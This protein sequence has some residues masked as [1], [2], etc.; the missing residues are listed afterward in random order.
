MTFPKKLSYLVHNVSDN[1]CSVGLDLSANHCGVCVAVVI[2][3]HIWI[4]NLQCINRTKED[5]D[6]SYANKIVDIVNSLH[7]PKIDHITCE[8]VYLKKWG[9]KF[10]VYEFERVLRLQGMIEYGLRLPWTYTQASHA[11]KVLS[12]NPQAHKAEVQLFVYRLLTRRRLP[13]MSDQMESLRQE[14]RQKKLSKPTFKKRAD[15]LSRYIEQITSLSEHTADALV[16]A[17]AHILDVDKEVSCQ[18]KR[19]RV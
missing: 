8:G 6:V 18:Q 5:S 15:K 11:R 13:T 4:L 9:T 3:Q 7:R 14:Y 10:N 1:Y 16:L 2:K 12:L 19:K 17:V